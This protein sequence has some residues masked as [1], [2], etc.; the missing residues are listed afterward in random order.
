[1]IALDDDDVAFDGTARATGSFQVLRK[2]RKHRAIARDPRDQRDDLASPAF[3]LPREADDT[4][5]RQVNAGSARLS[6]ATP[7]GPT[8][9]ACFRLA[10]AGTVGNPPLVRR[11]HDTPLLST[12][13]AY[14][15]WPRRA[16]RWPI[17]MWAHAQLH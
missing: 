8:L 2:C 6:R 16:P 3:P 4:I 12:H 7:R 14:P 1:M 5:T 11:P 9:T 17:R 15:F 13:I 10:T